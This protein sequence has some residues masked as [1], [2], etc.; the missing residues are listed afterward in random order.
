LFF[1]MSTIGF[2]FPNATAIALANHGSIAGMAS[3]LLGTVQFSMAGIAVLVLGAINSVTAVPMSAAICV[4]GLLGV[5]AHLA[6]L[7]SRGDVHQ[8]LQ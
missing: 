1:Y 3:A 6:L 2:V 4:C 8:P 5:A 7:G